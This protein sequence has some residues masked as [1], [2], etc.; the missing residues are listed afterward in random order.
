MPA[1]FE[2]FSFPDLL[3][4]LITRGRICGTPDTADKRDDDAYCE[5][6]EVEPLSLSPEGGWNEDVGLL[7]SL[8]LNRLNILLPPHKDGVRSF[9]TILDLVSKSLL[10]SVVYGL[11]NSFGI[12]AR[13]CLFTAESLSEAL[14][15]WQQCILQLFHRM[16][17]MCRM[18]SA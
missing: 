7:D 14:G 9:H 11:S 2:F 18:E 5:S 8:W 10:D 16:Q 12:F 13:R 4:Y 17:A 6:H 3:A 1:G 15:V